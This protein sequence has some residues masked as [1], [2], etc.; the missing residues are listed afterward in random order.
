MLTQFQD[1]TEVS[2]QAA[3]SCAK[4][5]SVVERK[6]ELFDTVS[7][8]INQTP[9]SILFI[10][11]SPAILSNKYNKVFVTAISKETKLFLDAKSVKYTYIDADDLGNYQK[12]FDWVI[13]IDEFLTFANNDAEQKTSIGF[14]IQLC[15]QTIV[16][17][18]R[19]YKNQPYKDKEF[20]FP[21]AT[22]DNNDSTLY[23][24]HHKYDFVEK[25]KWETQV[26]EITGSN[27]SVNGPFNRYAM[28]FKQLA[29][30]SSDLGATGFKVHKNL[31]YKSLIRKNYE[32]VITV[33][34]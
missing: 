25:S 34:V 7:K 13:A 6:Q 5:G 26:Y 20:S 4:L 30:V 29:K 12:A 3:D 33:S 19:D 11:F 27:L 15:K 22:Y 16:T 24:E 32:H 23:L 21:L 28:Y 18:L 31:M 1:Y 2:R 10:G 14:L 8:N 17:S 9:E